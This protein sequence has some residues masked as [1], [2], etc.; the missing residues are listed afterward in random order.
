MLLCCVT[1]LCGFSKKYK[2]VLVSRSHL[3]E[4]CSPGAANEERE[5]TYLN[6]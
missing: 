3:E 4:P 6:I 1:H 2:T 5:E